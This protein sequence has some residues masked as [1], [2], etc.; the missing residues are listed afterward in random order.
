MFV[1]YI[2]KLR[3]CIKSTC[4]WIS[5]HLI[6]NFALRHVTYSLMKIFVEDDMMYILRMYTEHH[7]IA[8]K[9]HYC[10]DMDLCLF[11]NNANI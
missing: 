8:S 5:L 10:Y 3:L 7:V 9:Y 4:N 11:H 2:I 6:N 1:T